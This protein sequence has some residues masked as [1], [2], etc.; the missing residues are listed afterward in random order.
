MYM[1]PTPPKWK[2]EQAT[3]V[4][5]EQ[6]KRFDE[7]HML[8]QHL[9]EAIKAQFEY[10]DEKEFANAKNAEPKD[11]YDNSFVEGLSKSGFLKNLGMR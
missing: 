4:V 3:E 10:L 7:T 8:G 5:V 11:F 6:R 9:L 2:D 1:S